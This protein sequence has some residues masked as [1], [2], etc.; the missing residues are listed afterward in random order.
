LSR[1]RG[2]ESINAPLKR[3][4]AL[5]TLVCLL[6]L[7]AGLG[8]A[9]KSLRDPTRAAFLERWSGVCLTVGLC[10]LGVALRTTR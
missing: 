9:L 4:T 10:L 5:I 3:I 8:L 2:Y 1:D 6:C 7:L